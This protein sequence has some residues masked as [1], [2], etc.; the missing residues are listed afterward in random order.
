MEEKDGRKGRLQIRDRVMVRKFPSEKAKGA[1]R[2]HKAEES[3]SE[4]VQA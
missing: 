1:D 4:E 3:K 2:P